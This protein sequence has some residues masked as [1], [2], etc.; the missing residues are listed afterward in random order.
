[1]M[2]MEGEV[3]TIVDADSAKWGKKGSNHRLRCDPKKRTVRPAIPCGW[4]ISVQLQQIGENLVHVAFHSGMSAMGKM[5]LTR[6][7]RRE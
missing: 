4:K 5:A 3:L 7:L 6:L 2:G 1:M